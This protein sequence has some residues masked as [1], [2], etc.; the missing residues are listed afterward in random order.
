MTL[1]DAI[2]NQFEYYTK[3]LLTHQEMLQ[4]IV[5]LAEDDMPRKIEY[6]K[7]KGDWKPVSDTLYSK[8]AA[9]DVIKALWTFEN[10]TIADEFRAVIA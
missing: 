6:R 10:C 9:K 1:Q 8:D 4:N 7:G 3:G 5:K 2:N